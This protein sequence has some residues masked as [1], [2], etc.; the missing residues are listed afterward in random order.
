MP[1]TIKSNHDKTNGGLWIAENAVT[2][3]QQIN[4]R[5]EKIPASFSREYHVL[6]ELCASMSSGFMLLNPDEHV[7]YSNDSALRLLRLYQ[8]DQSMLQEFDIHKHLLSI[9]SDPQQARNELEYSWLHPEQEVS[10]ELALA[11][12]AANWLRVRSF[13]V[14][15]VHGELL[16]RGV[17]L[18]DITLEHKASDAR[19]ETLMMAA[20]E[21]KT[22]LAIIK[23]CATT[24]L[25]GSAR[26]DPAM[27]REMLQMIDAQS[28]RLYDVLNTLLDV[29]RFDAGTQP[30]RLSQVQF[31]ELLLQ[32]VTRWQ[33]QAPEHRFI[34]DAPEDVSAVTCD[35]LRIEQVLN[36][37]LNNAV[38]FS[39]VDKIVRI[40]LEANEDEIRVS[41]ADEGVGIA[42][43]YLERI[44][45][46]FYRILADE[47]RP[48]IITT[49]G[50]VDDSLSRRNGSGL[51][52][53]SAR[54]TIEAHRGRIWAE[55]AG[56][57]QGTTF[58]FTLP[59]TTQTMATLPGLAR[60]DSAEPAGHPQAPAT[61]TSP[62]KQERRTRVL[63][64]ENDAR[65]TRYI[66][67][68]LEEQQ[69][70]VLAVSHGIQFLR[71][72]DLED[73]DLI[74]LS[75][76]LTDMSGVELL[77]RLREFSHAPVIVLS[78][79]CD[80]DERVQLFDLGCDDLMLKPFGMRELL[81]RI[82]A[83]LRRQSSHVER[84]QVQTTFTTGDLTIDFAQHQV[85]VKGS[86]VQLSR[87]EYKLLSTLAQNVGLVVTHELL[88]EKV[89]GPEYNRD[90]DFIW[91][92]ISR[93]RRKIETNSRR[94]EYILTV[95]DVGYK[96]AK[97]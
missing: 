16:G 92:Y 13:P 14:R 93:L 79:A 34:L 18:D 6:A 36:H 91:V 20:H 83:L 21:L 74:V 80:E 17:L 61:Y 40:Q 49:A 57:G 77:Q 23:G 27:Q 10:A 96:L 68:N 11:D 94:P 43:E 33:N 86:P 50:D 55:S 29:W 62:L 59:Y 1:P 22:P 31:T 37:L 44:F 85:S 73:P 2:L 47:K 84:P 66:R 19:A 54:S 76:H 32:L 46:R 3:P 60:R 4:E 78:D 75:T 26:W 70:R 45:D 87:T 48:H 38:T 71:Q 89:W 5:A 15:D 41:V 65:L 81:A 25:G 42:P 63:L 69:Y 35:A 64:A 90:I 97:V 39:S 88:L 24:L 9:A 51:G 8:H 12:A 72:L 30:L 7:A 52:L 95:P 58:Y 56:L 82:R 53:S 67:A 28:D